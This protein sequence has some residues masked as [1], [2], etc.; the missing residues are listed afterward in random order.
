MLNYIFFK[1]FNLNYITVIFKI[2]YGKLIK[3]NNNSNLDEDSKN[4]KFESISIFLV[5]FCIIFCYF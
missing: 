2:I 1:K 4:N 3:L 5:I